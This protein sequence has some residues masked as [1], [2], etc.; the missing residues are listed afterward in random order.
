MTTTE[1]FR[2]GQNSFIEG[3]V[4]ESITS[5]TKAL[6]EGYDP[7]RSYL[8]RGVSYVRMGELDKAIDDFSAVIALDPNNERGYYYRAISLMDKGEYRRAL[9]DLD[10]AIFLN[11]ERGT[12]FLARGL[13][14]SELGL[15][16]DAI[17]DF[18]AAVAYSDVESSGFAHGFGNYHTLFEKSMSLLEGDRGP[19]TI[20]LTGDEIR[21]LEK[22]IEH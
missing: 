8:S 17:S 6:D 15:E 3:R 13:V 11:H 12:S 1:L 9:E 22:W 21:K 7:V 5:F 19:L 10:H 16:N 4:K 20:N 2:I 14:K 18:K